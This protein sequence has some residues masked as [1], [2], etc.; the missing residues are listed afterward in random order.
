[1]AIY[2]KENKQHIKNSEY[3]S[4]KY[5]LKPFFTVWVACTYYLYGNACK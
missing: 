2:A 1:M 5:Y 4:E 3:V